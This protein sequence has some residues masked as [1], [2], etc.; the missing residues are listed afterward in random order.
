VEIKQT[1]TA[2][3]MTITKKEKEQEK[4]YLQQKAMTRAFASQIVSALNKQDKD[5]QNLIKEI[6]DLKNIN[7]IRKE[8]EKKYV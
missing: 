3:N 8:K 5:T 7:L 1:K 4:L 6:D 2:V